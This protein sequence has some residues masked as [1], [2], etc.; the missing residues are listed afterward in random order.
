MLRT[1]FI[2]VSDLREGLCEVLGGID[3]A[4]KAPAKEGDQRSASECDRSK[5]DAEQ[6]AESGQSYHADGNGKHCYNDE[7]DQQDGL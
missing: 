5:H 7:D 3:V 2:V 6:C 1:G 4:D